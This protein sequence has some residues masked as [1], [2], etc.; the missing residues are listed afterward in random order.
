MLSLQFLSYNI[1]LYVCASNHVLIMADPPDSP[2]CSHKHVA[3]MELTS[4]SNIVFLKLRLTSQP[5]L[6]FQLVQ[7]MI[8]KHATQRCKPCEHT[9]CLHTTQTL[10]P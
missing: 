9:L 3:L 6:C 4:H 8:S 1:H 10:E 5:L 2:I 7:Y